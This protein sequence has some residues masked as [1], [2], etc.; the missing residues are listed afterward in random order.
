MDYNGGAH[1]PK[2]VRKKKK[3]GRAALVICLSVVALLAVLAAIGGLYVR[4]LDTIY[5]K[6]RVTRGIGG[7]SAEEAA[8][9]L[10][11]RGMMK[12]RM[13]R[14]LSMPMDYSFSSRRRWRAWRS[15]LLPPADWPTVTEGGS[16]LG[17]MLKFSDAGCSARNC[18]KGAD[19]G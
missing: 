1:A 16:F 15:P 7:L 5:P 18:Q 3:S 10:T 12:T 14:H 6:V 8:D 4:G 9:I 2:P 11:E 13:R 17:H 19:S